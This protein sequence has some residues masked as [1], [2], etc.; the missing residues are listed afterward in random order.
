MMDYY[1]MEHNF[2]QL[3]VVLSTDLYLAEIL[4][5]CTD[6]ALDSNRVKAVQANV[7]NELAPVGIE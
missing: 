4:P 6:W 3:P 7:A 2:A 1:M 5:D